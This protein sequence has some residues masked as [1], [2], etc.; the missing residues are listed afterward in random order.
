MPRGIPKNKKPVVVAPKTEAW[1]PTPDMGDIKPPTS[2]EKICKDCGHLGVI[3][4]GGDKDWCNTSRCNC[5][6]MKG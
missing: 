2:K 4:Y 1:T 5:Q 3:H 6:Q